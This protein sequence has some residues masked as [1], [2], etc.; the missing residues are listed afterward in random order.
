MHPRDG[1]PVPGHADEANQ[2]LVAG[3]D[4]RL[5]RAALAQG[6][7]PLDHVDEIVQLDQ[8]DVVDAEAHE[9]A[10]NLLARA[11]VVALSSLCRE[12]EA[13]RITLQPG[14][15]PQLGV[16]VRGGRIDVV[17]AVL[18]QHRKRRIRLGLGER[19]EGGRAEDRARALMTGCSERRLRDHDARLSG[20][21]CGFV[22]V[23]NVIL[24]A[25]TGTLS[26]RPEATRGDR[27]RRGSEVRL[28][29]ALA[30]RRQ[31]TRLEPRARTGRRDGQKARWASRAGTHRGS[32]GDRRE[33]RA[34]PRSAPPRP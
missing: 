27:A 1:K 34:Q 24:D 11:G 30:A 28:P 22:A 26:V 15:E 21:L 18:E 16:A 14:R 25:A 5:E 8:V 19:A 17:D 33:C 2:S 23:G 10:A 31:A 20:L 4:R 13:P 12:K 3:L 6:G 7:L 9:R 32:G 29:V